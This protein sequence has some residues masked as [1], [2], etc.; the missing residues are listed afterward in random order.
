MHH[1]YH[2]PDGDARTGNGNEP[3]K[4]NRI[5]NIQQGTP[6]VHRIPWI[7]DVPFNPYSRR[8]EIIWKSGKL[9]WRGHFFLF[10]PDVPDFLHS[11]PRNKGGAGMVNGWPWIRQF[12][13]LAH[14]DVGYSLLDIGYSPEFVFGGR[15]RPPSKWNAVAAPLCGALFRK[16]A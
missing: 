8:Q 9:E 12:S 11:S 5:S 1:I 16:A 14:L 13:S 10:F 3:G 2:V 4:S 6:N 7:L 15:G